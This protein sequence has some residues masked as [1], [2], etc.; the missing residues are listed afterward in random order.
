MGHWVFLAKSLGCCQELHPES[1]ILNVSNLNSG[2]EVMR[3]RA[4]N[5]GACTQK[6][7]AQFRC[8]IKM[9]VGGIGGVGGVGG[10]GGLSSLKRLW[11]CLSYPPSTRAGG[12]N[13]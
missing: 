6:L 2:H 12:Q 11:K 7:K 8:V 5:H 10:I 3:N 9:A 4:L 13:D 1:M